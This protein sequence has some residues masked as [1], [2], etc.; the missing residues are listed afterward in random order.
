MWGLLYHYE[1]QSGELPPLALPIIATARNATNQALNESAVEDAEWDKVRR[2]LV[3]ER[4]VTD[5]A[6]TISGRT[7]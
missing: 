6:L 1:R 7:L 2:C 3:I 4:Q 5:Q